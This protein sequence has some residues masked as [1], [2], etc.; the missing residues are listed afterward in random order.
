M[1]SQ[2]SVE[3]DVKQTII[4]FLYSYPNIGASGIMVWWCLI[5]SIQLF[6]KNKIDSFHSSSRWGFLI[7]ICLLAIIYFLPFD[8]FSSFFQLVFFSLIFLLFINF[9]FFSDFYR[10]LLIITHFIIM[11]SLPEH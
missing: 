8:F 5:L 1:G 9:F 10:S 11:M 6:S 3:L 2:F 7:C 4:G